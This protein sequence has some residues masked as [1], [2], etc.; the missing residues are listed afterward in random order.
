MGDFRIKAL[1][2]EVF[3]SVTEA[4]RRTEHLRMNFDLRNSDRD[5]SQRMLNAI[6]PGTVLPIHRHKETSETCI[7]LRGSAVEI[8]YDDFGNETER[9][10]MIAGGE[11]CGCNIPAGAWHR[12]ESLKCGT[13]I[14]EAKD[15]A[16]ARIT[17]DDI[18]NV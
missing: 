17:P 16:Y 13:V 15:G 9:I 3:D 8:F 14:F 10:M 7:V 6:E 2:S 4:A 1:N 11:C 5:R 12:I 18:L